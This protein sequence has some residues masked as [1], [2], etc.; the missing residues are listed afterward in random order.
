MF[1]HFTD[2][3]ADL[4]RAHL[5]ALV[6]VEFFTIPFYLTAVYSFTN[7]ALSYT[8][9]GSQTSPLY[10]L[11]QEALSVAVQEMYHLQLASNLCNA[12]KVTPQI[13]QMTLQAGVNIEIPHLENGGQPITTQMGNL[14]FAIQAMIEVESPDPNP[15]FPPPNAAVVYPSISDLYHATLTLLAQY[16]AAAASTPV[17]LDP[18][19]DPGNNQVAYG[20]FPSTYKYNTI[21][22]RP[23]VAKV[24]NAVTDQGEGDLVAPDLLGSTEAQNAARALLSTFFTFGGDDTVLPEYQPKAGTRFAAFGALT[25][26]ARFKQIQAALN[27]TNWEQVIGGPVFYPAGMPSPDLPGWAA[28]LPTLESS[29]NT[30]WSYV[31]DQMQAGFADG[32]LSASTSSPTNTGF[33]NAMLSFKYMIPLVW[34]WGSVPS[35]VYTPGVTA[36]QVQTALDLA[37]PLCL[38]HWDEPTAQL[39]ATPGFPLNSCQG[40]NDCAGKGWGGIATEK[41]NGACATADLHTCGGNNDCKF[42]GGCGYL[43]TSS[44]G[45]C[46]ASV[47]AEDSTLLPPSEQWIPGL[48]DCKNLGGCETPI[49]TGQVFDRSATPTIAAQTGPEWTPEAKSALEALEGTNVWNRARTLFA[50]KEGLGTLPTPISQQVG[51][52]DYDGDARRRAVQ[53]TST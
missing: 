36:A 14:P 21:T 31:I 51:A 35:F 16:L 47:N 50:Q 7:R 25:H 12:F 22:S 11:Q 49:S 40:L 52:V 28:P 39:R 24:V 32:S 46:G 6:E 30:V 1:A 53:P 19:F 34:Q 29:M 44:G 18:A 13:P 33:N 8:P 26:L 38:S 45:G 43:S 2:N 37:D 48:N 41:G 27:G 5:Q 23:L 15:N 3:D 10:V 17:S 20:T 9:Q 4:L 42:Q